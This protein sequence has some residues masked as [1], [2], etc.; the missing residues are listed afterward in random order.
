ME[1]A[2]VPTVIFIAQLKYGVALKDFQQSHAKYAQERAVCC[3]E[4]RHG[5]S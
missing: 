1:Y 5:G 3:D 4:V 2:H